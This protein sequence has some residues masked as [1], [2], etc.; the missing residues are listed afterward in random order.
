M[1]NARNRGYELDGA[2]AL[3]G[4]AKIVRTLE[5][6]EHALRA[7]EVA[8]LLGVTRQHIYKLAADG[9]IPSFRIGSAVRFDPKHLAEWLRRKMPEVV[10]VVQRPRI[11]V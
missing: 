8:R 9:T 6:R 3:P 10:A 5:T 4:T 7:G 1:A 2:D 11:A